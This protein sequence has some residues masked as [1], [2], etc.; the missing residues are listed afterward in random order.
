MSINNQGMNWIRQDKRLAIYL[1]DGL[2]CAYCG[3]GIEEGARLTLDHVQPYANGGKHDATNLVTCCDNCNYGKNDRA[4]T[5]WVVAVSDYVNHGLTPEQIMEHIY[6]TSA[7]PLGEYRKQ[8]KDMLAARGS[9]KRI[10]AK[11]KRDARKARQ[12]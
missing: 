12:Q 3:N 7:K 8:A 10:I 6:T 1:R 9:V 2:A 5:E 11:M 4:M